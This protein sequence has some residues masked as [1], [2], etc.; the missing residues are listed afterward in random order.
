LTRELLKGAITLWEVRDFIKR[1]A[2]NE[3]DYYLLLIISTDEE[4]ESLMRKRK[5]VGFMSI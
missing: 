2:K 3:S 4:T 5:V 1:S